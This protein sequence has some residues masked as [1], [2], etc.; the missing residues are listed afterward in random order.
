MYLKKLKI[1]N[2]RNYEEE[3]ISLING[4]N[5]FLGDNAQ[6]KTNIIEA[7]YMNAFGKSYRTSKDVEV[8]N[9]NKEF[10]KVELE[11]YDEL[12]KSDKNIE[13][14]IDNIGRKRIKEEG[15]TIKKI[16]DHV[17]KIPIVIFSPDSLD[18]IKGSPQKRRKFIDSICCQLSKKYYISL[19]EYL[20]CLKLKNNILKNNKNEIDFDYIEVLHEKMSDYIKF[21]V[22]YRKNI[23]NKL[24]FYA[25][26]IQKSITEEKEDINIE[27]ISDFLN[28][29]KSEIKKILDEYLK[30]DI[31]RK[32]SVKG[33]QKDDIYIYINNKEVNKYGSQGQ[34]RTSLLTLE[35]SNFELLK[36]EI[37]QT[38]ILLLDDIMSELDSKRITFLLEYIKKYQ[39]V[40]TTTDMNFLKSIENIKILKVLN[41]RLENN[42]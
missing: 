22:E 6:G 5:L 42:I 37:K 31:I 15:V 4:I 9:F 35:L 17:G 28:K 20:K 13:V 1:T 3:N 8:I 23:V 27:Y 24:L 2:F 11:I 25:K 41:G 21:I 16:Q 14:Y 30:I 36:E 7:I 40:I 10:L 39:S 12:E 33:I 18:I 38:P 32:M 26:N 19:Q 34:C 29:E